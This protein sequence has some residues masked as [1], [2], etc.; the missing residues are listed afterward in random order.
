MKLA[1]EPDAGFFA[2]F[3]CPKRAFGQ[4]IADADQFN[5]LMIKNTGV[6]GVDF[7]QYIRYAICAAPV[8]GLIDEI[9]AAFEKAQVSY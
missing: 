7:G 5:Q 8:E 1:V 3:L 9:R 4:D 6:V 2:L